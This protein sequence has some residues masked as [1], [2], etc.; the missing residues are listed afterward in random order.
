[1]KPTQKQME[2]SARRRALVP[3]SVFNSI[4]TGPNPMTPDELRALAAK[5]PWLW[6]RF[7]P[8]ADAE[9]ARRREGR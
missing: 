5:R 6:A 8:W 3:Y 1:M 4:Q 9:D 2:F 7:L